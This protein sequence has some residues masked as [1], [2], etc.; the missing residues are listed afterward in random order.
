[1]SIQQL[2]TQEVAQVSGGLLS[3]TIAAG[4]TV[5]AGAPT[6]VTGLLGTV[7][8]LVTALLA[9]V[10]GL[11]GGLTGTGSLLGGLLATVSSLSL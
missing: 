3:N 6:L 7:S 1:M 11:V 8:G 4:A 10:F 2:N 5:L 9:D